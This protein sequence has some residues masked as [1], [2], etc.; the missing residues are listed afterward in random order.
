MGSGKTTLIKSICAGLGVQSEV[1]I[2]PTYTL[3]NRYSGNQ[4]ISHVDLFR[5][6]RSEELQDFDR[7]DLICEEGITL[8][9]WPKLIIG[10][11]EKDPL[12]QIRLEYRE[13]QVRFLE[14]ESDDP[15]YSLLFERSML[16]DDP[17]EHQ[18]LKGS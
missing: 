1:V 13:E 7:E 17:S 10:W 16:K 2:S 9:E 6:E 3:V 12:L 4:E 5:L 14:M 11:L 15:H 18:D 8:V